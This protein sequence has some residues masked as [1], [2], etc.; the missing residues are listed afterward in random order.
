MTASIADPA[1]LYE[2]SAEKVSHMF[3]RNGGRREGR[4]PDILGVNE[5]LY[6]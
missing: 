6:H 5:A 3:E 2:D 1:A 4:T